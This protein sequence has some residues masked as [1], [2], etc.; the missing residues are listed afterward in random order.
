MVSQQPGIIYIAVHHKWTRSNQNEDEQT[1]STQL[2]MAT[3]PFSLTPA[4]TGLHFWGSLP[5]FE[6]S[7]RN[8]FMAEKNNPKIFFR[9]F[10]S[11]Q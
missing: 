7:S 1:T 10:A 4:P 2:R 6:S 9:I 5:L 11:P 3:T 8:V